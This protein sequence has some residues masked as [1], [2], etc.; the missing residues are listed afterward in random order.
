MRP[1]R[2]LRARPVAWLACIFIAGVAPASAQDEAP[3][4]GGGFSVSDVKA[5]YGWSFSE[6]GI[7]EDVEK[8]I[9]T[10]ENTR[11]WS[12]GSSYLF[13][14]VLRSWSDADANAKEAYGEWYPSMSLRKVSGRQPSEKLI[15]DVS[16]TLGF[17]GGVRTTGPAP[18][19]I[20][21]GV[22][23]EL[24]IPAFEFFSLG[25]YVYIDRGRFEGHL[26]GCS[27]TSYQVTPSWSLPFSIG[28]A[29]FNF[30][31]FADVIGSHGDCAF[32]VLAQPELKLDVSRLWHNPGRMWAG[33]QLYYWHNKYGL[34]DL[35]DAVVMPVVA[36]YF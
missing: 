19:V 17:N 24:N 14:D 7:A 5:R 4:S 12:W 32:Q 30:R 22:T 11:A 2:A 36:W 20:L 25:T 33:V 21:P 6:P 15:R 26:T 27:S 34:D 9:L 29:A 35:E 23:V 1:C 18:F 3:K 13:V 10:F 16:V 31:G 28:Q 8:S